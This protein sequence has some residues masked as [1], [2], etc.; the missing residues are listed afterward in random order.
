MKINFKTGKEY[1]YKDNPE[2]VKS[3]DK[4]KMFVNGKYIS[5]SHP[6]YKAGRYKSFDE[7]A[8]SSLKLYQ[9][10]PKGEVYIIAHPSFK[11]WVKIGKAVDAVDR[12]KSYQTGCPQRSYYL[13]ATYKVSDRNVSE[14]KAHQLLEKSFDRQN[15]WFRCSTL[16]AEQV[17]NK[18]FFKDA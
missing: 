1:Y 18:L 6:L 2:A 3:R 5:K 8:F 14:T 16:E 10:N 17:L 12:L 7:A 11:N 15:E 4:T 9:L 13:T